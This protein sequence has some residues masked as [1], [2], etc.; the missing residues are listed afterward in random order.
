MVTGTGGPPSLYRSVQSDPGVDFS[1]T[2]AERDLVSLCRDFAQK[3]IATRAPPA[4]DDARCPSD[5]LRER[6]GP[7]CSAR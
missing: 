6:G 1:L 5:L 4:W 7:A 2:E 3:E